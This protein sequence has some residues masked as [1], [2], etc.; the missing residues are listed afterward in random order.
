MSSEFI[1]KVKKIDFVILG[2]LLGL[3]LI[4]TLAVYSATSSTTLEGLYKN[5]LIYFVAFFLLM[6]FMSL[7]DY[8]P[9]VERFSPIMYG[10]GI[11]LLILLLL[12]GK[13]VNGSIRWIHIG[14]FEFQPSELVKVFLIFYL[15]KWLS[16]REGESLR[17]IRDVIPACIISLFPAALVYKQP[18]MGTAIILVGICLGMLW[19]ANIPAKQFVIGISLI[20]F[21]IVQTTVLYFTKFELLSTLLKPHQLGRIQTF[22]DPVNSPDGGWHVVNSM[23]AIGSGQLVGKGYINGHYVHE[24]FIP[25][26]YSDSIFVVIGEEF[27]FLGSSVLLLLYIVLIY[28]L[29]EIAMKCTDI[30]GAYIIVGVISMIFAQVFENIAMHIGMMPLTGIS[31]PFVSYG[32]SSLLINMALIGVAQSV[33]IHQNR[34]G[35]ID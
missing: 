34:F 28:R 1:K 10:F 35:F 7:L 5:N 25:Y 23:T 2:V 19:I 17:F 13:K 29:V 20:V 22:L 32:G 15:A 26:V 33:K 9:L 8:R 12:T 14:S 11:L 18:D 4:S 6:I 27:G 16:R 31:L 21:A 30:K 24:G 3:H